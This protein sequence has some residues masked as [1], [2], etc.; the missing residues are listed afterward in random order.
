MNQT[1]F[2]TG[3][4]G[5]VGRAL[6][7]DMVRR[8]YSVR[9]AVRER[10]HEIGLPGQ[11]VKIADI[12]KYA[13]WSAALAGVDAVVHLAARVHVMRDNDLDP[14]ATFRAVNVVA[15]ERIARAA[16]AEG[17]RRFVY[18]SSIKVNGEGTQPGQPYTADDEPVPIG[19]YGISKH[20]AELALR[21]VA[22]ETGL[23]VVI[24]RPVLVYG[25]GVR[26]N[27]LF[28]MRCLNWG[29]PLPLGA[30]DNKRSF[31]AL[32]NLVDLI[33]TCSYHPDAPDQTFLVSDGQDLS[34][35]EL[36]SRLAEALGRPARL[37][38]V[39]A[40]VL[41]IA[42]R[43]LRNADIA[44]RLCGSLQV[45]ITKTRALLNWNPPVNIDAALRKTAESFLAE[46][47]ISDRNDVLNK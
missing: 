6:S 44:E 7:V 8:G 40:P 22:E 1:I 15:T 46:N 20:E 31:V 27:F 30:I 17:V 43:L 19:P 18:V 32:D 35:T 11:I 26:A 13:D 38:P 10:P 45:D 37:I 24:I 28:M 21:I 9:A 16:V 23:E 14:L 34:T 36:L 25:P 47:M 42:A 4:D 2:I 3:A 12:R 29:I 39:P 41:R 5:F 33:V